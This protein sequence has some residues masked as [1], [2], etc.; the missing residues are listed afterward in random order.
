M[1][2]RPTPSKRAFFFDKELVTL[3]RIPLATMDDFDLGLLV[4]SLGVP[5]SERKCKGSPVD[6]VVSLCLCLTGRLGLQGHSPA[7]K[8]AGHV[9]RL[10]VPGER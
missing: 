8:D 10:Y 5:S 2:P 4:S 1:P 9:P 6:C 7:S 3:L